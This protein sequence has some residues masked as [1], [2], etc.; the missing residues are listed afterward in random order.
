MEII[1]EIGLNHGGSLEKAM[2]MIRISKECDCQTVKFQFYN[3]DLLCANRNCFESYKL[4]D[5]IKMRPGWIP[6]LAAECKRWGIE[7]LVTVFD[8]FGAEQLADYVTRY[9]IASPEAANITFLKQVAS[10]GKPLLIS[11]GKV[12]DEKL[13][14]IFDEIQ[15][16]ISLLYCI[17]KYPA[18]PSDYKLSEIKRLKKR[19]SVPVGVSCHCP[20]IKNA[21]DA[22]DKGADIVEKHFTLTSDTVDAA[23]S[24]YPD[25]MKKMCEIIRRNNG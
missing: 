21:L 3:V 2:E 7:F 6:Y 5:K 18:L 9:K 11:T 19:Y 4:L 24:I 12:D 17:S 25:D 1:S 13:D 22:V 16:P 14:R 23:V 8:R 20:G 10:F 15:T